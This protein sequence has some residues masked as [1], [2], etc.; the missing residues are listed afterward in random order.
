RRPMPTDPPRPEPS[1]ATGGDPAVGGAA[2]RYARLWD[3]GRPDLDVFLHTAGPL[4]PD[5]VGA[6]LRLDQSRRWQAGERAPVEDYLCRLPGDPPDP[7]AAVDLIYHEYLLRERLGERPDP[8][9]FLRRFPGH[10]AVLGA[11]IELH[12]AV[13]AD[14]TVDEFPRGP[15]GDAGATWRPR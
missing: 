2:E 8:G 4:T 7:E 15:T 10:A 6:V 9:E 12:R 5:D 14:S 11:Q 13:T 1:P 3:R